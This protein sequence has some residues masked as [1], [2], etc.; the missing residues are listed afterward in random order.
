MPGNR[1]GL[2]YFN[3][4]G[5]DQD[6][7]TQLPGKCTAFSRR[8]AREIGGELPYVRFLLR[9][10]CPCAIFAGSTTHLCR[11]KRYIKCHRRVHRGQPVVR[12]VAVCFFHG[13]SL[14]ALRRLGHYPPGGYGGIMYYRIIYVVAFFLASFVDITIIWTLSGITIALITLPNLVAS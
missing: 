10:Y 4:T 1:T 7:S 9:L 2:R 8:S 5:A 14:V 3:Q 13:H 11:I 12:T 6:F